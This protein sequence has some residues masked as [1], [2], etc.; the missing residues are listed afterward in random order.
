MGMSSRTYGS[1]FRFGGGSV[2]PAIK[3][4]LIVTTAVFLGQTLISLFFGDR[5]T[6]W[7]LTW[8][9]LIPTAVIPGLRVWQPFTYLFLHGGLMHILINLLILWMFGTDLERVWGERKFYTY[10]FVCGVGAGL[11][12]V[13]AAWIPTFFGRP[14]ADVVTIGASG[15]IFGVLIACAIL[16]PDR[17]VA[18]IIPPVVLSM[19]VFVG[20]M[21]AIEFF[22]ELGAGGDNVSHICHLGGMLI[23]Y[24]YLRR[25]SFFFN[26]RNALADWK[27]KRTRKKFEVYMRKRD[28]NPPSP[29]DRWVN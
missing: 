14:V 13:A 16:F 1:R 11:V 3:T 29:P 2:T 12:N 25:G 28:G 8:F 19:R 5:G 23:G 9:G 15:A 7:V 21:A 26:T 27:R 17:Q 24:L 22:S 10:Y 20:V 6:V 18:L 4:L